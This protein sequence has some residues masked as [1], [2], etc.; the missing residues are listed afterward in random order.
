MAQY[1][2]AFDAVVDTDWDADPAHLP[3]DALD[4]IIREAKALISER[5]YAPWWKIARVGD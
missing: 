1:I 3:Q 4:Q 2:V 5:G